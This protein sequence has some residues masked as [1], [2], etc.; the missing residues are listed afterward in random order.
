MRELDF[1]EKNLRHRWQGV[2]PIWDAIQGEVKH[3]VK[4][5][6]EQ[7]MRME[8]CHHLRCGRYRRSAQRQGYRNGSYGRDLLT[9]YGWIASLMVP[10]V[11][12]GGFQPSVLERYRRRQR[13]VDQ[14]LLET[15]L[16]GH[17]TRKT[18]R[19]CRRVFGA[20]ISAQGVSNI[21]ATLDG[22][23]QAFHRRR[24][25][26]DYRVL[27]LDGLW[28]TLR[29]PVRVQRVVLVAL[30]VRPD[31]REELVSFQLAP[32]ESE[33]C[34]WG[35]LA[36]LKERGLRGASL[37]A[38]VS[39]G[40]SGLL[41]ALRGLL[42][43]VDHQWCVWHKVMDLG[44]HL[45]NPRHRRAIIAD[46]FQIFEAA[47]ASEARRRL[48]G[49]IRR[50]HEREVR[51]VRNFQRGFVDCLTYLAFPEPWRTRLKTNSRLER[52]LEEFR[53]RIIP[54]RS[55]ANAKSA[56][57]IIYG[58]IAYVLNHQ[59]EGPETEFTQEG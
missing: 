55:F 8:V 37:S 58:I 31:G 46:A 12:A 57:R 20:S 43:R 15:F 34:W 4:R 42:P 51:A 40:A 54:M 35:F 47:T 52:Y 48:A 3:Q 18:R 21:V 56:N 13:Q 22:E 5:R 2:K 33:A 23:V 44:D 28:I 1:S 17:A 24:L 6:L 11:R 41:K 7:A 53:R 25:S 26:D 9:R 49:F 32:S 16:L 27:Y 19:V 38:I 29:Q 14:V 10:R 30:G 45:V 36:D 59:S 50:W 39:D